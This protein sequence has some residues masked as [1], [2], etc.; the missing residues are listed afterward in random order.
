MMQ[1][2]LRDLRQVSCGLVEEL[3]YVIDVRKLTL[4]LRENFVKKSMK[5]TFVSIVSLM[6]R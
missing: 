4:A 3:F 6:C 2:D 5:F 1:Q